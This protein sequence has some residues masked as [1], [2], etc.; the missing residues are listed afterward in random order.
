MKLK[1][2]FEDM[3]LIVD[4]MFWLAYQASQVIGMGH[5][6]ARNQTTKVEVLA[7]LSLPSPGYKYADYIFG[8]MM[9]MYVL[10]TDGDTRAEVP[11]AVPM[12]DYQSWCFRYPTYEDLFHTALATYKKDP[13]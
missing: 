9:K 6:Q 7:E 12:Y 8:R 2:A 4:Q 3:P 5:L 13:S 11:D 10:L 1:A